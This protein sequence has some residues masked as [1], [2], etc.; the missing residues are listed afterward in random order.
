MI[1]TSL[2]VSHLTKDTSI[3][4]CDTFDC[5]V[6][7]VHVPLFVHADISFRITILCCHLSVS[8]QLI[9]PLFACNKSSFTMRCRVCIN[10]AKL[11]SLKPWGFVC[12][13]LCI[14]HLRDMTS[15][16]IVCQCRSIICL[17]NDF[18]VWYKSEN[19]SSRAAPIT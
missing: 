7:S 13:N 5:T 6:R 1:S 18:S 4:A 3:R 15:D 19:I 12:N 14:N 17:S 10:S 2:R 11:C 8:E 9:K 16:C